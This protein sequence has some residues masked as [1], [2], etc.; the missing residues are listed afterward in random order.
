M[1][2]LWDELDS[3]TPQSWSIKTALSRLKSTGDLF[4]PVISTKQNI[5][6]V[7][8]AAPAGKHN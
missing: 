8:K 1:P 4:F 2:V 7:L 5:D 3:V 6:S